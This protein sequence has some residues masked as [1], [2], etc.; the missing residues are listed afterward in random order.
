M[1]RNIKLFGKFQCYDMMMRGIDKLFWP[2]V[3]LA[4]YNELGKLCLGCEGIVCGETLEMYVAVAN[5][6]HDNCPKLP[7]ED[8]LIVAADKFLTTVN[9]QKDMGFSNAMRLIDRYHLTDSIILPNM[10]GEKYNVLQG[11][12]IIRWSRPRLCPN[13]KRLWYWREPNSMP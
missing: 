11:H 1:R 6:V 10:F 2:Y 9:V 12:L 3:S 4:L 8:V 7:K 5:F 13:L